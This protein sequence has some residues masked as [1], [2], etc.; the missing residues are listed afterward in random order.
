[1]KQVRPFHREAFRH[2]AIYPRF[3]DAFWGVY[4]AYR[5]EPNLRFHVFAA[6]CVSVVG[7]AVGLEGWEVAYLAAA[8]L[9]VLLAEMFNTAVER[10]V[11]LA[12]NGQRLPLA[13][14]GK[15]VAAG[16]VLVAAGHATFAAFFLFVVRRGPVP[17]IEA[18]LSLIMRS[19]WILILPFLAGMMGIFG[20]ENIP[21]QD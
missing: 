3:R 19:P 8:I 12:A 13:A 5:E 4:Q 20:G 1:M 15:Q 11:D 6:T 10:T 21:E 9:I 17:T 18:I 2:R 7:Y 14:Q 16:A